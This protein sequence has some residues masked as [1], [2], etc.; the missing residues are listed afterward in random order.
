MNHQCNTARAQLAPRQGRVTL[1]QQ[2]DDTAMLR[3]AVAP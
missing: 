2:R 3:C 1:R